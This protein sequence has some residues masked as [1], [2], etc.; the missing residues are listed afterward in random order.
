MENVGRQLCPEHL[1]ERR[2][3]AFTEA[4]ARDMRVADEGQCRHRGRKCDSKRRSSQINAV[5]PALAK[6]AALSPSSAVRG[7]FRTSVETKARILIGM[8]ASA[9]S[10]RC[11]RLRDGARPSHRSEQN[12]STTLRIEQETSLPRWGRLSRGDG[13]DGGVG[14]AVQR[15]APGGA[16]ERPRRGLRFA[17]LAFFRMLRDSWHF[18]RGVRRNVDRRRLARWRGTKRRRER[19]RG[20]DAGQRGGRPGGDRRCDS[21]CSAGRDGRS[22]H[23][24]RDP[25]ERGRGHR[26]PATQRVGCRRRGRRECRNRGFRRER[27]R[28]NFV[29]GRLLRCRW[30]LPAG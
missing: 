20:L 29:P 19:R 12:D 4:R 9:L 2:L 15:R 13:A 11:R 16:R 26:C 6:L 14:P 30:A 23:R 1:D 28:R 5:S 10:P 24:D 22:E 8:V 25:C 7:A 27:M 3:A 17:R 21:R 18:G